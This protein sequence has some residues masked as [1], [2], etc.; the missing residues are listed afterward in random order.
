MQELVSNRKFHEYPLQ[1]INVRAFIKKNDEDKLQQITKR[2]K[3]LE[4]VLEKNNQTGLKIDL[5]KQPTSE[6]TV[7]YLNR[8][9]KTI[10]GEVT[11]TDIV[12]ELYEIMLSVGEDN[13][14][15]SHR[16]IYK[17]LDEQ[18]PISSIRRILSQYRHGKLG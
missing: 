3:E 8:M 14:R 16:V 7:R 4:D 1:C 17:A 10:R 15:H 18:V 2:A 9:I 11:S 12:V 5:G 13:T 6:R